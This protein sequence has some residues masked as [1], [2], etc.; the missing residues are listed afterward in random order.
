MNRTVAVATVDVELVRAGS[1]GGLGE[2]GGGGEQ[3]VRGSFAETGVAQSA[4]PGGVELVGDDEIDAALFQ[5]AGGG[6]DDGGRGSGRG[7]AID[8]PADAHIEIGRA[9][10]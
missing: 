3:E 6:A 4:R 9:H 10:V 1:G 2:G 5:Q 7:E 8:N